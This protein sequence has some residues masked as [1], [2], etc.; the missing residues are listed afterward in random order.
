MNEQKTRDE[1]LITVGKLES[2]NRV[3][4][5]Q[6]QGKKKKMQFSQKICVFGVIFV[7]L[8]WLANFVLLWFCREPM[9]DVTIAVISMFGGFATGGYFALSGVRDCSLNKMRTK[10]NDEEMEA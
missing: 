7:T 9:S 4:R 10:L 3:L 8:A 6:V 1:M 5:R 2:E